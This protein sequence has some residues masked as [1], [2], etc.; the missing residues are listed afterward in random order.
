MSLIELTL[1][2]A[3]A[4]VRVACWTAHRARVP[5]HFLG[6]VLDDY[7]PGGGCEFPGCLHDDMSS[8]RERI[9]SLVIMTLVHCKHHEQH[10][11][12]DLPSGHHVLGFLPELEVDKII[13]HPVYVL[14]VKCTGVRMC[15]LNSAIILNFF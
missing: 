14:W 7:V 3:D 5:D 4:G 9:S 15:F 2:E 1:L 12:E 6:G 11:S 8:T 13:C 10:D